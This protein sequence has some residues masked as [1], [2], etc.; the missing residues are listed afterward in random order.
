MF[1]SVETRKKGHPMTK[2]EKK[3]VDL[4][5]RPLNALKDTMNNQI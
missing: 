2:F 5:I 3:N 4:N 1:P